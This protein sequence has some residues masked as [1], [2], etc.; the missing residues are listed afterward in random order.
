MQNHPRFGKYADHREPGVV[1]LDALQ[2]HPLVHG[3][4][5]VDEQHGANGYRVLNSARPDF[6]LETTERPDAEAIVDLLNTACDQVRDGDPIERIDDKP[7]DVLRRELAQLELEA[8]DRLP[9]GAAAARQVHHGPAG[10]AENV[11]IEAIREELR[12]RGQVT[13]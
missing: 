5:R 1:D 7:V 2:S 12:R 8:H 9:N 13:R 10:A 11:R 4:F 3:V 6:V